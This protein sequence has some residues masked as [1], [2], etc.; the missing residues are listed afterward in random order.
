MKVICEDI[1]PV[2]KLISLETFDNVHKITRESF[3]DGATWYTNYKSVWNNVGEQ[4]ALQSIHHQVYLNTR[5]L[6]TNF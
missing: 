2:S 3:L 1:E 6:H 4:V 5:N